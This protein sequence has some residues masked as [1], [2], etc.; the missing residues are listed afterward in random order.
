MHLRSRRERSTAARTNLTSAAKASSSEANLAVSA[1]MPAKAAS[2][3]DAS[4]CN[5]SRSEQGPLSSMGCGINIAISRYKY[6][7]V[8]TQKIGALMTN[9]KMKS[10]PG[11]LA[12][13]GRDA[14]KKNV[15]S[16]AHNHH[17]RVII[18]FWLFCQTFGGKQ[19][20]L[21]IHVCRA[22]KT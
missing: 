5:H 4:C 21:A 16:Y 10:F 9:E 17:T 3:R 22:G 19:N 2:R 6:P 13:A 1:H 20:I 12:N 14:G 11:T 7:P 15:Q 8:Q 18:E